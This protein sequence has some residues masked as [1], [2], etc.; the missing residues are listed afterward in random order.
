[1]E[2]EENVYNTH[3]L[4]IPTRSGLVLDEVLSAMQKDIRRGNWRAAVQWMLDAIWTGREKCLQNI[5]TLCWNRLL[6][7]T[8]EDIGP[9]DY[10]AFLITYNYR[11]KYMQTEDR[12]EKDRICYIVTKYLALCKKSRVNDWAIHSLSRYIE[13]QGLSWDNI[14]INNKDKILEYINKDKTADPTSII[15][16]I[17]ASYNTGRMLESNAVLSGTSKT[18]RSKKPIL[19]LL[20]IILDYCE[21]EE[22]ILACLDVMLD[23]NRAQTAKINWHDKRWL[24]LYVHIAHVIFYRNYPAH[25]MTELTIAD[26]EGDESKY[27]IYYNKK[28]V[29]DMKELEDVIPLP[30]Y[31]VD[32]HT[33]RG[34][35][36]HRD[37]LHFLREG[38]VI[39]NGDRFWEDISQIYLNI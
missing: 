32:M 33:T 14:Y 7:I 19:S 31:A 27:R 13:K 35:L 4:N 6:I 18:I 37:Y 21:R 8:I 25:M 17:L 38:C 36:K 15:L 23:I 29:Y 39:N 2:F 1:M 3:V 9:A 5:E 10:N 12:E 34:R 24:L 26:N 30:D 16:A 28:L 11:M 22:Y 20:R